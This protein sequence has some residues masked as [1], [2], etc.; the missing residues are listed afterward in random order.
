MGLPDDVEPTG[1]S[2]A[3]AALKAEYDARGVQLT[4]ALNAGERTQRLHDFQRERGDDF[5]AALEDA[6][7]AMEK[8]RDDLR[9]K[10]GG[11]LVSCR[12]TMVRVADDLNL[13]AQAADDG[14]T[15][16]DA[17]ADMDA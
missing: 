12:A 14:A 7:S 17:P 3:V 5:R 15:E 2:E 13:A 8:A 11:D 6:A 4:D 16:P 9:L 1:V 10:A